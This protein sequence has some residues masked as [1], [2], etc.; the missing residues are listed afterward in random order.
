[1]RFAFFASLAVFALCAACARRPQILR[2]EQDFYYN[3]KLYVDGQFQLAAARFAK[4]REQASDPRDADEAGAEQC[5]ATARAKEYLDA[6]SCYDALA[7]SAFE[8]PVRM[9]ALLYSGELRYDKLGK[10]ADGLRIFTALV[11]KAPDTSA[12]L[13]AVDFLTLYGQLGPNQRDEMLRL[14]DR[15]ETAQ[16][17]SELADNLLFRGAVLLEA[18]HTV[19]ADE[20]AVRLLE[21]NEA[22]HAEASTIMDS[23]DLH[24]KLLRRLGRLKEEAVVLQT[25]VETYETSYV[26]ASYAGQTHKDASARLVELYRG[27]LKNLERAENYARHLPTMLHHPLELPKYM[28]TLAEIQEERG[29]L[30]AAIATCKELLATMGKR[31]EVMRANDRRICTESGSRDEQQ[32]CLAEI[33]KFEPILSRDEKRALETIARLNTRAP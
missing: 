5:E 1:M 30:R 11:E 13:R 4:L 28:M 2:W 15:L 25:I 16:P 33:A 26:F 27:P 24:V 12:G 22:R 18:Q 8:R 10:R 3:E 21:R 31:Q 7:I 19:A 23:R 20:A 14:F 32:Q 6:M 9:R 29:N 17:D